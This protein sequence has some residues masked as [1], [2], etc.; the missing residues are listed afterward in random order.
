MHTCPGCGTT[1]Q[2]YANASEVPNATQLEESDGSYHNRER[3]LTVQL[4][5]VKKERDEL[6]ATVATVCIADCDHCGAVVLNST[7]DQCPHCEGELYPVTKNLG[8]DCFLLGIALHK[9]DGVA[10]LELEARG[11]GFHWMRRK[12]VGEP[13]R[14][15]R[16][17]PA[18]E[19]TNIGRAFAEDLEAG[20]SAPP[21]SIEESGAAVVEAIASMTQPSW[22]KAE[23]EQTKF[24]AHLAKKAPLT[25]KT[26]GRLGCGIGWHP[27]VE[28]LICDIEKILVLD[29]RL[30]KAFTIGIKEKY[31]R[32]TVYTRPEDDPRIAAVVA[33][34]EERASKTC[35]E[36]GKPGRW[37]VNSNEWE[38]ITC[39]RHAPEDDTAA[40][41]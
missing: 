35:E 4:A 40:E 25:T 31:A 33:K 12:Y 6:P 19:V 39:D 30:A 10:V 27:I 1:L 28:E 14:A 23:A 3:C 13:K 20:M 7:S 32:L 24:L 38:S 17:N 11:D 41:L 8:S 18:E 9:N 29:E 2:T 36:C 22:Q 5:K 21:R 37:R 15:K 34:A 26:L 16:G